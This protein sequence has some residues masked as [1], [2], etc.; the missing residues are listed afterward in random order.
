MVCPIFGTTQSFERMPRS[1]NIGA[2]YASFSLRLKSVSPVTNAT[3][4]RS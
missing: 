4:S 1:A 2:M 3:D